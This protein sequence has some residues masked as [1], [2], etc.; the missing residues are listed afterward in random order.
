MRYN[1][2]ASRRLVVDF[3]RVALTKNPD[4]VA[5]T[6]TASLLE[7]S[8]T[9]FVSFLKIKLSTG[10][11]TGTF[12]YFGFY[13]TGSGMDTIWQHVWSNNYRYFFI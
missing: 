4:P 6:I 12:S 11:D 8:Y 9:I 2:S 1:D 7:V 13:S 3:I 5:R 10:A